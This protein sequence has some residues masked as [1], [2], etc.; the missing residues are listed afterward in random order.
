M[1]SAKTPLG[2]YVHVPFCAEK[3]PYCDF[4]S[5]SGSPDVMDAYTQRIL[6]ALQAYAPQHLAADTLYFGG[7]TP[8]LLG[9]E[10][11]ARITR[12]A[13]ET[14]GLAGAEI[15]V[16]VNPTAREDDMARLLDGLHQ[17]GVNRLSLGLQSAHPEE[18]RA[19]GRRHTPEQAARAVELAHE[20]G[21]RNCSLDLMLAIPQQTPDSLRESIAFCAQAG[22]S[23]VSAYL[24]KIEPGTAF[25]PR[26]MQL[27]LPEEVV[28]ERYLFTV[29]ELA[30][31]GFEQYEI[32][33]FARRE[34]GVLLESRH[35]TK[36][37]R[38]EEVLGFGPAAHSYFRGERF[39]QPPD[40]TAFLAGQ[41][42][43][44]DGEGGSREEFAMLALR[45]TRGLSDS[46]WQERFGESLP[47]A[48]LRRARKF[49]PP[50]LLCLREDEPGFFLTP[51]GFLVSN[52]LIGEILFGA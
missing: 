44:P 22:A 35:N 24:L 39:F 27:S 21:F 30:R 20:C 40:L 10:R 13:R 51:R 18:L 42:P 34:D 36:Y 29:Q 23:H 9:A 47:A 7:G 5:L 25:Y 49:A 50:G 37:W 26:K 31:Q 12:A 14:F 28:E 33:N 1:N 41:P 43:V 8:S 45:L 38:G 3:C 4:Y 16:E 48:Y 2:I 11:L 46:I 6:A 52:A 32:S 15:T 17:A 19:L